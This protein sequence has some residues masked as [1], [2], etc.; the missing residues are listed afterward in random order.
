[1][2]V[3]EEQQASYL[4]K[5]IEFVKNNY[6][7]VEMMCIYKLRNKNNTSGSAQ[8]N[9]QQNNFGLMRRSD[10]APKPVY[11][12]L[13]N[14]LLSTSVDNPIL[15]TADFSLSFDI[16]SGILRIQHNHKLLTNRLVEV[17]D[18]TGQLVCREKL[19]DGIILDSYIQLPKL[20]CGIYMIQLLADN[21]RISKKFM[22]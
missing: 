15:T 6:A 3:T 7:Y 17:Y 22:L 2:G 9:L 1:M 18:L 20:T 16:S 4:L 11:L 21:I 5:A 13:Q 12:A 14:Y 19:S 8:V 10:Y